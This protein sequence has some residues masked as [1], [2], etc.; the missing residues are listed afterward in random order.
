VTLPPLGQQPFLKDLEIYG[1]KNLETIGPEF[2]YVQAGE[3]SNSSFQPFPSLEHIKLHKM[4]NWKE[5]LPFE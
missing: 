5:W 2:Y 3:G 4:P 1:M